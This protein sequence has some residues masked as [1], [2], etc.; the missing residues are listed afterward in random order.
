MAPA[1]QAIKLQSAAIVAANEVMAMNGC[2]F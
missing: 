1:V 2:E